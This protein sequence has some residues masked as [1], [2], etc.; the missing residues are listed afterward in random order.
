MTKINRSVSTCITGENP[1]LFVH[2]SVFVHRNLAPCSVNHP[3][4][5]TVVSELSGQR[6]F[7]T[8]T[9]NVVSDVFPVDSEIRV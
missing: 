8:A 1:A 6:V 2:E 4:E 7:Q 3:S 9:T 5:E